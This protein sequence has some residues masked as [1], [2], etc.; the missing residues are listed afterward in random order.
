M[1][2][3]KLNKIAEMY[4]SATKKEKEPK[5]DRKPASEGKRSKKLDFNENRGGLRTTIYSDK[6]EE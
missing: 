6:E 2:S 5:K 1:A 4:E 3:D